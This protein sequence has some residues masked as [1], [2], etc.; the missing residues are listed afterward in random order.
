MRFSDFEVTADHELLHR[1][2]PVHLQP[3]AMKVL[4]LLA[5]RAGEL[6]TREQIQKHIWGDETHVDFEQGLNWC[7][8]RI[9]EVLGDDAT[10][11]RFIQTVPR[12]GYRFIAEVAVPSPQ[13]ARRS[14]WPVA[15][16][17]VLALLATGVPPSTPSR[18]S[19]LVLPFDNLGAEA[20]AGDV[21]TQE[22]IGALAQIDPRRLGV[23][24]PLTAT[25]LK[26]TGE[27]IVQLGRQLQ[28]QYVLLGAVRSTGE[29]LR[30]T[31]QL[32]RV[33]DNQ[34]AWATESELPL[35]AEPAGAYAR[36]AR[37]MASRI[38]IQ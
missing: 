11:P 28:T 26:N 10:A 9:R 13:R 31:A 6:V 20:Y 25:K 30:V 14:W 29:R 3:Q 4:L 7:I 15:A 33:A 12:R 37:D 8:G 34:Q 27:C 22:V 23:I 5:S 16:S 32:F 35:S 19:I 17:L 24:D 38:G 2:T 1:G 36:M 21:A 18:V